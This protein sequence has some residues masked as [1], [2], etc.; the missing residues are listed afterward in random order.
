MSRGSEGKYEGIAGKLA[1]EFRQFNGLSASFFRVAAARSGMTVNDMQVIDILDSTGP[2]TAG[3]I[4]DLTG[5]TTGAITGMLN[6]LEGV[7]LVQRESDPNDGRR[8]I[9]RLARDENNMQKVGPI[10]DEMTK[11][12]VDEA[13]RY[14]DEQMAFLLEF[15]QRSNALSQREIMRLREGVASEGEIF[16]APM[17]YVERGKLLVSSGLTQLVLRSGEAMSEL[18]SANFE[19]TLPE[20]KV[21][22]GTVNIRYP[23]RLWMLTGDKRTAE[24]TLNRAVPWEIALQGGVATIDARLSTINLAGLEIKGGISSIH[25]ELPIPSGMVP[26]RINGSASDISVR[27]PAGVAARVHLKGWASTF[28][29]DEQSFSNMGNDVRMQSKGFEPTEPFYD[30]EVMSSVSMVTITAE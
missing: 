3:Q 17:E 8:V 29:F 2:M 21:K 25:L 12:W 7:G 15:L 30:I 20:V 22:E 26:I 16:S 27:R 23:R 11:A 6:R 13:S 24:I 1:R 28:I 14:S 4:A 9:V 5:L 10:F 19:G 18:Y